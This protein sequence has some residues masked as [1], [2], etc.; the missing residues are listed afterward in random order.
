MV[1]EANFVS[2]VAIEGLNDFD[3]SKSINLPPVNIDKQFNLVD[4]SLSCPPV[5][6]RLKIDV[7]AKATALATIGVAV[8]GTILPPKIDSFALVTSTLEVSLSFGWIQ[9]NN[10]CVYRLEC[11]IGWN[12]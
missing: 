10:P 8:S 4:E 11:G 3:S 1:I 6:A 2:F 12:D 7:D 9:N 5:S